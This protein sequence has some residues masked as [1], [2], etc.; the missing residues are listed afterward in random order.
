M[1]FKA[2]TY[3]IQDGGAGREERILSVIRTAQPDIVVLQELYSVEF[4]HYLAASLRMGYFFGAGNAERHVALLSRFPIISARS[5]HPLPPIARNV[6]DADVECST[7]SVVRV[8]GVHPVANLWLPFELWRTWEARWI[9]NLLQKTFTQPCLIMG[10]FNAIAPNDPFTFQ[11][12]PV[13]L[14]MLL[15]SQGGQ[16]FSYSIKMYQN[17]GLVDCYRHLHL[18]EQGFTLPAKNPDI[19]LD[20]VFANHALLPRLTA[21]QVVREPEVVLQASDHLPVIV[22]FN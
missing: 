14:K 13:W 1:G 6:I 17:A 7:G 22:E 15:C 8:I 12:M 10:D 9:I 19:R 3:N 18:S 20:Y 11:N 5:Y 16:P 21:C 4:V 2:M